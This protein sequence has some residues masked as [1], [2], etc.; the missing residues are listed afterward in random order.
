MRTADIKVGTDYAYRS[1]TYSGATQ[2]TVLETAVPREEGWSFNR[3]TIRNGVRVKMVKPD[4]NGK[5]FIATSK[6]IDQEWETYAEQAERNRIARERRAEEDAIERA[7]RARQARTLDEYLRGH[8]VESREVHVWRGWN[9]EALAAAGFPIT[10]D[11]VL[12]TISS[13][14]DLMTRGRVTLDDITPLLAD[15][16]RSLES[17]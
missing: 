17:A 1:S 15:A 5:E 9:R 14:D 10:D 3:R 13:L 8:G 6:Q 4:G 7:E 16:G 11:K 12:T 2:V